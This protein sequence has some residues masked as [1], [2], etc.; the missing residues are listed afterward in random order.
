MQIKYVNRAL[1]H[2]DAT[3]VIPTQFVLFTL[4]V[5]LGSAVLYRDFKK[6]PGDDAG[7]FIG[8]CAMT[9]MGV[10]LITSGRPRRTD[11]QEDRDPEPEDAINLVNGERYRDSVDTDGPEDIE[12]GTSTRR[13]STLRDSSPPIAVG[14]TMH[15][16]S[17]SAPSTPIIKL[18]LHNTTH[19]TPAFETPSSIREAPSPLTTNP[20]ESSAPASPSPSP[21]LRPVPVPLFASVSDPVLPT[22]AQAPSS[23]SATRP[24]T[25][26][27]TTHTADALPATPVTAPRLR[28]SGTAERLSSR[29][30]DHG[31]DRDRL[32]ARNSIAGPLLASPLGSS[33]SAV[34]AEL[35]RGGSLRGSHHHN[36]NGS[37]EPHTPSR[38]RESIAVDGDE[39]GPDDGGRERGIV[40]RGTEGET[41]GRGRSLSGT[42]GELWRGWRGSANTSVEDVGAVEAGRS[43]SVGDEEWA[44][45]R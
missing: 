43:G 40:R 26:E 6:T 28:R 17:A 2:F 41:T 12:A 36:S 8:G 44:P 42:L 14:R 1:Q 29:D 19:P 5:I 23:A 16:A 9:F 13:P 35:R 4:S 24:R 39:R 31:R 3:Q 45:Q 21:V 22:D 11:E 30:R 27:G 10:W 33:L 32:S 25:P 38:W 34:V 37:A 20:W 7:K 18:T 15:H